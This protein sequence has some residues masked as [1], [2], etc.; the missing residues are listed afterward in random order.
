MDD[1]QTSIQ[2]ALEQLLPSDGPGVALHVVHRGETVWRGGRGMA[3]LEWG[4]PITADTVFRIGSITKQFTAAAIMLLVEDGKLSVD[5][6]LCSILPDY[7]NDRRGSRPIT[8]RHL[9]T[10]TSG[11]QNYTALPDFDR[12]K[13]RD[14]AELIAV[15]KN[16]P[17][18]FEPGERFEYCNSGYVLLGAIIEALS[19]QSYRS[20][21]LD[22][23]FRPLQ[24]RDTRYLFD[25]AIIARR[26][27]GYT[28]GPKGV[29]NA[30][31]L[32]MTAPYSAGGLGSTVGDLV[33]WEGALRGGKVV[34]ADSY[35]AMIEPG[36][37]HDGTRTSCG[38]G[39]FVTHYREVALIGHAGGIN[40]FH[41]MMQHLPQHDITI[42]ALSNFEQAPL[43]QL[44][45]TIVRRLLGLKDVERTRIPASEAELTRCVG[46]YLV[47][48][49]PVEVGRDASGITLS[50]PRPGSRYVPCGERAF[51]LE[52]D[53]E[54]LVRFDD[55]WHHGYGTIVLQGPTMSLKGERRA[56]K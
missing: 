29:V 35:A 50:L 25:E 19:G 7:P 31:T 56:S 17:S 6:A 33:R 10:H 51:H 43:E 8:V 53:P 41:S 47:Q 52:H 34:S 26:A 48:R 36:S 55:A 40:G 24:L 22:R 13:D 9:L 2:N 23:I 14:P 54:V 20:F 12:R 32:S 46:S 16:L 39:L 11:L 42:A 38:F 4:L 15:F 45:L 27:S 49:M 18:D 44:I 1:A 3:N 30:R 37:L 28:S 5:D 21:L